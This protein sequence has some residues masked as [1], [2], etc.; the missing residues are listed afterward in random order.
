[1]RKT[2]PPCRTWLADV[3]RRLGQYLVE[4]SFLHDLALCVDALPRVPFLL[5]F[6][7]KNEHF[8]SARAFYSRTVPGTSLIWSA[9]LC[10]LTFF[11]T[12]CRFP[13]GTHAASA[14]SFP[15]EFHP[16]ET[17][18]D[19]VVVPCPGIDPAFTKHRDGVSDSRQAL[20]V[21][22]HVNEAHNQENCYEKPYQALFEGDRGRLTVP[23][24][25][26]LVMD[27]AVFHFLQP[28]F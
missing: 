8:S 22:G 10:R 15:N 4:G 1:M 26:F 11:W 19:I 24:G 25:K 9:W 12:T 16:L 23:G 3:F 6:N 17:L 2:F 20:Q 13:D 28:R 5:L 27:V 7:D 14:A 21:G 18:L